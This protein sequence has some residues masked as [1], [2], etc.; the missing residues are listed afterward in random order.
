MTNHAGPRP[1]GRILAGVLAL[2]L[3][4]FSL[5][6]LTACSVEK[7]HASSTAKSLYDS[8]KSRGELRVGIRTDDPPHGFLD[9]NG[10]WV[11]FDVDIARAI[12]SRWGVKLKIMPV[13]ELTRIS[14]LQ[15]GRIDLAIAS[16][17]KTKKRAQQVDFSETYFFSHQ[18]FLVRKGRVASLQDLVGKTVGADR[19][20]S[21]VGNWT[22]WVASHGGSGQP[23]IQLFGDK[24]AA[25]AA[26]KNGS[27][28]GYAEDYEILA[29]FAKSDPSLEVLADPNGIGLKLDGIAMHH[30]DSQLMLQVNLALQDL[31]SS[32]QYQATYDRWF[33]PASSTPVP[34]QG[35]IEVWPNG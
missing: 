6:G 32:G 13:D 17:S 30:N 25:V 22:T 5:T 33:G 1:T 8:V 29:S 11:G 23:H 9:N 34:L 24:H 27:I 3:V 20:S 21:A 28:A 31:Q 4:A 7:S 26:V 19:G 18:T 12:A 14:Y 15:N 35:K 16:I 2:L 10:H